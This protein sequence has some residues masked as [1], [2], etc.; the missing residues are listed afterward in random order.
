LSGLPR[1]ITTTR[2]DINR[3]GWYQTPVARKLI[4]F[5]VGLAIALLPYQ[6]ALS[7]AVV[8]VDKDPG[9]MSVC[10]TPQDMPAETQGD[11]ST[12]CCMFR[13]LM[14]SAL[15]AKEPG[16][17]SLVTPQS[18]IFPANLSIVASPA[19]S[20]PFRPPRS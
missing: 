1:T 4:T 8:P 12:D 11:C 7:E 19:A 16:S 15:P 9:V 10:L 17:F 13:C 14:F 20:P 5:L 6:A 18:P 2:D 3:E